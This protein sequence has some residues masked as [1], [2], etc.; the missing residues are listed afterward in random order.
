MTK[1]NK[2]TY[3]FSVIIE[4]DESGYLVGSV[5]A[6]RNCHTQA[7]TLPVLYKRLNEVVGLCLE[8]EKD[9]FKSKTIQ[10]ELVGVQNLEFT[11]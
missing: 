4:K 7:K 6:L 10:N 3:S 2:K 11:A 1:K 8:V 9:F 5:P